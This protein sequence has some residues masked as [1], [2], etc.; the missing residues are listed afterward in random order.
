VHEIQAAA[1]DEKAGG[2]YNIEFYG[3]CARGETGTDKINEMFNNQTTIKFKYWGFRM[4]NIKIFRNG[5]LQMTGLKYEDEAP[6][7]AN[8]LMDI[9]SQITIPINKTPQEIIKS[10]RTYDM[11]MLYTTNTTEPASNNKITYYRRYYT[12]FLDAYKIDLEDLKSIQSTTSTGTEDKKNIYQLIKLD[13]KG[14]NY[15]KGLHDVYQDNLLTTS[16]DMLETNEWYGDQKILTVINTLELIKQY[17]AIYF[18]GILSSSVSLK[19]LK[20]NIQK[21]QTKITDFKYPELSSIL[22]NVATG[23]YPTDEQTLIEIKNQ[24]HEIFKQYKI[25]LT[26]KITRLIFI[27]NSDVSICHILEEHLHAAS[28]TA[29]GTNQ[30]TNKNDSML[31]VNIHDLDV[32][33]LTS[34]I[35]TISTTPTK[36]T[37]PANTS[38]IQS[39][40]PT[41]QIPITPNPITSNPITPNPYGYYVSGTETV[42]INSDLQV[43]YNI[44]LKKMAKILKKRGLFNTYDPDEHSGVNLK[45]YWNR[46]YTSN[47]EG[48]CHCSPHCSTKEKKTLCNKITVLIFRPG[49][50]VI[51]GSRTLEQLCAAHTFTIKLLQETMDAVRIDERTDETKQLALLNNEARKISRKPRLFYIKKEKIHMHTTTPTKS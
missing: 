25:A 15:I 5:R 29:Q 9:I 31:N 37:T 11:Q 19:E 24:V 8:L 23:L 28:S 30:S 12:R 17:G 26:K 4:V 47:N 14:K 50:I 13:L 42:M 18:E 1:L 2:L 3:N 45:Y 46:T 38:T 6:L 34:S 27:R 10:S 39:T 48:I 22:D 32:S 33:I 43:N 16:L 20:E 36:P 21:F 44:N 51:T 49:S 35:P 40:K 7:L 41:N